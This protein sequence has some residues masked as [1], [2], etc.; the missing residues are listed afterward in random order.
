MGIKVEINSLFGHKKNLL[1]SQEVF[2]VAGTGLEP[3]TFGL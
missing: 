3:V 1:I 2:F